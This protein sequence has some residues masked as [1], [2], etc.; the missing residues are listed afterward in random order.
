MSPAT[1]FTRLVVRD[2]LVAGAVIAVAMV[3]FPGEGQAFSFFSGCAWAVLNFVLLAWLVVSLSAP[4]RVNR[5]FT[6]MLACAKIPAS[7]YL[8]Y[9]LYRAEY[10]E[11]VSLTAGIAL[12][13][14]VLLFRGLQFAREAG[15]A[16]KVSEEGS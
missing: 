8:L 9:W 6:F 1:P 10:L 3:I 15:S 4:K 5:L 14:V 7:Y 11:P 2:S 16:K 12:L 13:P